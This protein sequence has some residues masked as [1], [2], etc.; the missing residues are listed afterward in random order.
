M[1]NAN[2]VVDLLFDPTGPLK[3]LHDRVQEA[4]CSVDPEGNP[5]KILFVP[6]TEN[7]LLELEDLA[8]HG[9][10]L[11][12]KKHILALQADHKVI[13]QALRAHIARAHRPELKKVARLSARHTPGDWEAEAASSS[14]V[15]KHE[16]RRDEEDQEGPIIEEIGDF[17]STFS[18]WG[19]PSYNP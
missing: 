14:Q 6:C 19:F 3:E 8:A 18:G 7:Q 2:H 5:V 17:V 13:D 10:E 12:R 9:Y 1:A 15:K 16:G 11:C 4:G